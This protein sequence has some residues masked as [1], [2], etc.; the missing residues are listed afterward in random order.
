MG[1][2]GGGG[3]GG[4]RRGGRG[5][6]REGRCTGSPAIKLPYK[7]AK[8]LGASLSSDD[9]RDPDRIGGKGPRGGVAKPV[10]RRS[11]QEGGRK[12]G[13]RQRKA[14]RK[15]ARAQRHQG[16]VPAPDAARLR[17]QQPSPAQAQSGQ[18]V[19][20][21]A[22]RRSSG[23]AASRDSKRKAE[24]PPALTGKAAREAAKRRRSKTH[25]AELLEDAQAGIFSSAT[26]APAGHRHLWLS[27][28]MPSHLSGLPASR[29]CTCPAVRPSARPSQASMPPPCQPTG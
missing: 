18:S 12:Y 26:A 7:L 29:L 5:G 23:G 4:G 6:R 16:P 14:E 1:R 2:R 25:F 24:G 3:G 22:G 21:A 17:R 20:G 13:V 28:H 8:E 27:V 11:A 10:G 15:A 19:E 9:H